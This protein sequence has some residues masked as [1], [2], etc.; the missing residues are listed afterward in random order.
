LGAKARVWRDRLQLNASAY[1][2]DWK[3]VQ[4]SYQL[5]VCLFNYVANGGKARSQGFDFSARFRTEGGWTLSL[6]TAYTDARYTR[7]VVSGPN[8]LIRKGDYFPTPKWSATLG[9]EYAFQITERYGAYTRTDFQ[10]QGPYRNGF[11]RGT[12]N[13]QPDNYHMPVT[14]YVSTRAGVRSED[15]ELSLFATNLLN[16]KVAL[17]KAGGR[18]GCLDFDC[19]V[20]STNV[21]IREYSS[22]APRRVGVTLLYR[23]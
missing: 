1:L 22:F 13:Y 20:F 9:A 21:P 17:S 18:S 23:R 10:Y 6:Q 3:D 8:V 15:W 19:S 14:V 11:G 2:L 5:P 4:V 16:S 12:L 7:E